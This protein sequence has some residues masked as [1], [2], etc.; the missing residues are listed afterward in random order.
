MAKLLARAVRLRS[1]AGTEENGWS[2]L[3]G[4]QGRPAPTPPQGRR[5]RKGA[6]MLDGVLHARRSGLRTRGLNARGPR[7]G[8]ALSGWA[9]LAVKHATVTHTGAGPHRG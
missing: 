3:I 5:H 8:L 9:A 4:C 2:D 1:R 6:G 7:L